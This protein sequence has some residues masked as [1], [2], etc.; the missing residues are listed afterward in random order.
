MDSE[1]YRLAKENISQGAEYYDSNDDAY[2]E[3]MMTEN[4]MRV[5]DGLG[6]DVVIMGIYGDDHCDPRKSIYTQ[7]VD[8]MAKRIRAHYGDVVKYESVMRMK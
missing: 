2:H 8:S 6:K 5:Y 3:N 7:K 4:F 1:E